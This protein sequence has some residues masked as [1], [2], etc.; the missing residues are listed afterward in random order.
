MKYEV[1]LMDYIVESN[2]VVWE[3]TIA[4]PKDEF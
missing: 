4:I 2:H 3:V 1:G